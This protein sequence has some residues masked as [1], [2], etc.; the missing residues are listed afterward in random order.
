LLLEP[1]FLA[2]ALD[3]GTQPSDLSLRWEMGADAPALRELLLL[4][5]NET[6]RSAAG[7]AHYATTIAKLIAIH[8]VQHYS[9]QRD[10]PARRGGLSPTRLRKV[11]SVI[12]E[13]L[14]GELSLDELAQAAGLSVFHFSRVFR[15]STGMSP[16]QYVTKARVER[17]RTLLLEPG[18]RIGEVALE[19]GFCDQAHLTRHFKR[20]TG[21][22]P[23][24]FVRSVGYRSFSR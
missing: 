18:M 6:V 22:T 17:A 2:N 19:C 5:R 8:L 15:Q 16:F 14:D 11:V 9:E 13:R 12:E 21:V 3:N 1:E 24:V 23:A 20:V 7:D 10:D 4:L